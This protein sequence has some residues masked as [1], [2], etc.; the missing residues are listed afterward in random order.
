[1]PSF[2]LHLASFDVEHWQLAAL[3]M[4]S[5]IAWILINNQSPCGEIRRKF[6]APT[7]H[8]LASYPRSTP[9]HQ[10]QSPAQDRVLLV[11]LTIRVDEG[12]TG[13]LDYE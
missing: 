8:I 10:Q 7:P 9:T 6:L 3:Y 1:L 4:Q 11:L 2:S 13:G 12:G 5:L